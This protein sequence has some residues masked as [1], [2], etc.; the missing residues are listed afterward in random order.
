M[1][2]RNLVMTVEPE[3]LGYRRERPPKPAWSRAPFHHP[4]TLPRSAPAVGET[5]E[6]ES[7]RPGT[8]TGVPTVGPG[9]WLERQQPGVVGMHR[10]PV[11]VKSLWQQVQHP[12]CVFFTGE[13]YDEVVR[14]A[15]QER[16]SLQPRLDFL[17]EPHV[18]HIVQIDVGQQRRNHTA[19]WGTLIRKRQVAVFE[20]PRIKPFTDQSQQHPIAYPLPKQVPQVS[21]IQRVEELADV[22][23]PTPPPPAPHSF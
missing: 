13:A 14:I 11:P 4:D 1:L 15:D 9:L 8:L 19:L 7:P 10:Q 3:P 20:H 22:H 18:Q 16:T 12:P 17:L 6:V 21:M 23:L 2:L 5:Q